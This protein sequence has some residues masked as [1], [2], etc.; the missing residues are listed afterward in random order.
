MLCTLGDKRD[1]IH[2]GY[3]YEP[4]LDGIRAICYVSSKGIKLITRN[5]IDITHQFPEF[6]FIKNIKATSCVI[7]GEIVAYDKKGHPDFN[8]LQN[9]AI[10]GVPA[11][12]VVFD[13]LVKNGKSLIDLPLLERKNILEST[14]KDGNGLEVIAY[15]AD[16]K[17]L[18]KFAKKHHL[19]GVIAKQMDQTYSVAKRVHHWIKIKFTKELE[20][21]I[22]GF[23]QDKRSVSSLALGLYQGNKL[24][25]VGKVGTGFSEADIDDLYKKFQTIIAKKSPV[26]NAD[27]APRTIIWIKLK[28]VADI[29][30]FQMTH[31]KRLRGP[32]FLHLRK[33]KK[34]LEC[35]FSQIG[36]H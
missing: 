11:T 35:T 21:V 3:I 2:K 30:Y 25:Y 20:C 7:D 36:L 13:I 17:K 31:N 24:Y 34:P 23:T 19:E 6:K 5:G 14:L 27:S 10:S 33:D 32:V 12:F 28:F 8:L 4:K 15:S 29:K 26:V 9:R 18:W 16:G 22:I 1:L